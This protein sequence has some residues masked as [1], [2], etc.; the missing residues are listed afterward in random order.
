M[1]NTSHS[2]VLDIHVQTLRRTNALLSQVHQHCCVL[3]VHLAAATAAGLSLQ[4]PTRQEEVGWDRRS[5]GLHCR[6][7]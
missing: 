2:A 1:R 4:E 7:A 5:R 6:A 3:R